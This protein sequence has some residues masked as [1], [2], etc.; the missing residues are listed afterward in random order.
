M[1]RIACLLA[2]LLLLIGSTASAEQDYDDL[3]ARILDFSAVGPA[4]DE[5][6]D[7]LPEAAQ[8]LYV[9]AIYDMEMRCGGVCT[10]FCNEGPA[11]ATRVSDSRRLLGLDP[12]ADAYEDFVEDNEIDLTT[13]AQFDIDFYENGDGFAEEYAALW[14][15]YPFDD[16]DQ[17]YL[18]QWE[19]LNFAGRML[20]F[21]AAHPEA[22]E[23]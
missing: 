8:T 15:S 12:M 22:F 5:N 18:D 16:F 20:D 23:S 10:F 1:K 9:A 14:A 7:D 19:K 4:Y 6:F 21:A 11:V 13:L 3:Y 2:L 17:A